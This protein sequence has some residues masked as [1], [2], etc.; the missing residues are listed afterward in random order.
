MKILTLSNCPLIE[1]QGS[2]YVIVNYARGMRAKGHEVD[3]FGPESLEIFPFIQKAKSHRISLGMVLCALRH[4][5]RKNYD[6]VEFYGCEAWL[7]I[8]LLRR[9]P[10]RRF[11]LVSHSNGLEVQCREV[12]EHHLGTASHDGASLR[13]YQRLPIPIERAF[14]ESDGIVTVS[15]FDRKFA[16][17]RRYQPSER[18]LAIDNPLPDEFL[19]LP[20]RFDRDSR[21]GFCGMWIPRKGIAAI[22]Q[23]TAAL[24]TEFPGTTL[25]FAGVGEEFRKEE[26]FPL[27]LASR[28]EVFPCLRTKNQL[29]AFYESISLLIMP[30][31]YESFGLV[32][33]EAMACGCAVVATATGFAATLVDREE[34][35]LMKAPHSPSLYEAVKEL[36]VN[37][38]FRQHLARG[39]YD[40]VQCLRWDAAVDRLESTYLDWAQRRL[41]LS[42]TL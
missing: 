35:Q 38:E 33:A 40:R 12:I 14:R 8:T 31:I 32:C 20:V 30:S 25:L 41:V 34:I 28:I 24:L 1:S 10:R 42:R 16:V 39:G 13:W 19:G 2:G 5:Y 36:L 26:V 3:L 9:I 6:I 11:A 4:I 37:D 18:V 15:E 7:A 17:Q 23:D 27:H 21:I 22:V 29:R